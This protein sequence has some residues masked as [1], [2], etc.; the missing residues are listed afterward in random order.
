[1]THGFFAT[2]FYI[3][4]YNVLIFVINSIPGHS[5]GIAVIAVTV[6]IRLVL[7]PLSRKSIKTQLQMRQIE[8][9]VQKIK[10]KVK[11]RQEQARQLMQ[12][13]KDKDVN[14]FAGLFLILIQFPI[15]IGLYRVFISGLPKIDATLLYSFVHMPASVGMTF[16]GINLMQKSIIVAI[17]TVITQFIQLNLALPS[18]KKGDDAS[19]KGDLAYSMNMQMKYIF[20]LI[21]FPIAYISAVIGLYLLTS[22]IFMI[23]QELYVRKTLKKHYK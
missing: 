17:L 5:A 2:L 12:L 15:L 22:N 9:E 10:E 1:M 7:Y 21:I 16:L 19:F 6:I 8:P 14:P 3:P 4:I 20:P 23:F 13:Y 18:V 11:D